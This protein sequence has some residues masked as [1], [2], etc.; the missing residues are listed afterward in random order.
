MSTK[1]YELPTNKSAID[2]RMAVD[3]EQTNYNRASTR[4]TGKRNYPKIITTLLTTGALLGAGGYI[5][6]ESI[7][8]QVSNQEKKANNHYEGMPSYEK[9][10]EE[11]SSK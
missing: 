4:E 5:A 10:K 7:D 3:L 8:K 9:W 1:R 11:N 6:S 2:A